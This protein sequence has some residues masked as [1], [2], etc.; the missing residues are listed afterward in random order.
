[1][2]A[3]ETSG[4]DDGVQV[5]VSTVNQVDTGFGHLVNFAGDNGNV[6]FQQRFEVART[7]RKSDQ[8][9]VNS[10]WLRQFWTLN[11]PSAANMKLRN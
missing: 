10:E 9:L 5:K 3:I 6:G 7:G 2:R 1:M 11:L 8:S 4:A